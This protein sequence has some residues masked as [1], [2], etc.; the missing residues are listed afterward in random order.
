MQTA[1]FTEYKPLYF[2]FA[3]LPR[4]RIVNTGMWN[5]GTANF[6]SVL[7]SDDAIL[8]K[9]NRPKLKVLKKT[10]TAAVA[11]VQTYFSD[12]DRHSVDWPFL[13][14]AFNTT[15]HDLKKA[16]TKH[17]SLLLSKAQAET[18]NNLVKDEIV[19]GELLPFD[20]SS[21]E[22][23]DITPY[24]EFLSNYNWTVSPQKIAQR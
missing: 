9:V 22:L 16:W 23:F 7:A 15:E 13:Q 5:N 12:Q 6:N 17:G 19:Q 14:L 24:V 10:I 18:L 4:L 2:D 21:D 3:K 1:N 20:P 11:F 8:A